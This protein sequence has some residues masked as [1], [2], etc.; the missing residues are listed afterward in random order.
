M[1]EQKEMTA[2][3]Q[4]DLLHVFKHMMACKEKESLLVRQGFNSLEE[5]YILTKRKNPASIWEL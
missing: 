1:H 4:F 2:N 3:K 5:K